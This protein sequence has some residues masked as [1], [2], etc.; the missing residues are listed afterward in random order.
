[1]TQ[2]L[3]FW[4]LLTGT[5]RYEKSLSTRGRGH[6]VYIDAPILAYL[7]ETRN[8]RIL[9]D[10][11]CDYAKLSVPTLRARYYEQNTFPFGPPTMT[12]GQ[13]IPAYLQ[14]LGLS[15]EDVD[16][17]FIG[18]LHFDHGG[19]LCD[20]A[21]ADV[22]VHAQELEAARSQADD[23]YFQDDFAGAYRWQI[24]DGEYDLVPGV[25]AIETPGHT[26]GHMSMLIK[27]PRGA[28]ILLAGDAADLQEN[29]DDEVAPGL[30]WRDRD[31][32]AIASIRKLKAIAG[33]SGAQLWPN[34]DLQFFR[35]RDRFP[36]YFD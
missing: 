6:G 4:P 28:P 3:K 35:H 17:V 2:V 7:I 27:L 25:S 9:Y 21:H 34:H 12:A 8:G 18:H 29:L 20:M 32:L 14:R 15:P 33:E 13:R 5:H 24:A 30:C 11:G 22:H 23:A 31:D 10:L 1:M 16:A 19:G 36:D 26:A